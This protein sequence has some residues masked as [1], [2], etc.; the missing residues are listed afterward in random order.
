MTTRFFLKTFGDSGMRKTTHAH[1][2]SGHTTNERFWMKVDKSG[3]CWLWLGYR[4]AAG[5][6]MFWLNGRMR[7]SH[8]VALELEHGDTLDRDT[9]VC[10]RC[11][12]PPCVRPSHLFLG[13]LAD[14][15]HDRDKKGR[16][17]RLRGELNGRCLLTDD[18]AR[19]IYRRGV[20][21]DS[22]AEI[23]RDYPRCSYSTVYLIAR[24]YT[25]R[26]ATGATKPEG[27]A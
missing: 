5:Y 21:G 19:E 12:N 25:R 14:N 13:S 27:W 4:T 15:N 7:V 22:P 9:A 17:A 11:D 24:G 23:A 20:A 16:Q 1:R 18:E 26:H 8:R 6:G 10:H 3:D 2:H